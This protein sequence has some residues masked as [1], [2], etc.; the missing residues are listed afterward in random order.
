MVYQTSAKIKREELPARAIG[1][2]V[3]I[4]E[5]G[6]NSGSLDLF[7]SINSMSGCRFSLRETSDGLM[8]ELG[9]RSPQDLLGKPLTVYMD[10]VSREVYGVGTEKVEILPARAWRG[11]SDSREQISPKLSHAED[12]DH[13]RGCVGSYSYGSASHNSD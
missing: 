2:P 11:W 6:I 5:A 4:H 12:G 1:F 9:V 13:N 3:T 8:E 10:P 7:L